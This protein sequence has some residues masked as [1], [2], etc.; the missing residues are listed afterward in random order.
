MAPAKS[1]TPLLCW[2]CCGRLPQK[3]MVRTSTPGLTGREAAEAN[4]HQVN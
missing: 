2:E 4:G 1:N 3:L